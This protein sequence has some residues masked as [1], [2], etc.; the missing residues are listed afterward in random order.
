MKKNKVAPEETNG[1]DG[2]IH[3]S[4]VEKTLAEVIELVSN[5]SKL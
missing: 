1:T 2:K 3:N 5:L 4:L